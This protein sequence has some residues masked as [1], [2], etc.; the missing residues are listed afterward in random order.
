MKERQRGIQ[1]SLSNKYDLGP[2]I[3]FFRSNPFE[4]ISTPQN[5]VSPTKCCHK[6]KLLNR[7]EYP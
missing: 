3:F 4:I 5:L 7:D 1:V 6:E 2:T